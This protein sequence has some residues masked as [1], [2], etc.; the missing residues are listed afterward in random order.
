[1]KALPEVV[2]KQLLK[3]HGVVGNIM[4]AGLH[5][6]ANLKR[7]NM[8]RLLELAGIHSWSPYNSESVIKCKISRQCDQ[9]NEDRD[10]TNSPV[11]VRAAEDRHATLPYIRF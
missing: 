6:R 5:G 2:L 1:M 9:V 8:R 11:G 4:I 7:R 10:Q 3:R